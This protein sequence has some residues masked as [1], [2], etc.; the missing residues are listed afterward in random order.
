MLK[1]RSG[2]LLALL[3]LF[4]SVISAVAPAASARAAGT[5][6]TVDGTK[7]GRT[8]DG[9]GAISGG[10]GNSRLLTDY[11]E[12]QRS[13]ILD[14]LFKPGYGAS[15]QIL[16]VEIGGDMNSTDGAEPS[17]MHSPD[18]LNCDRGY[19]WWLM[20][21][22]KKRNPDIKLAALSWGA[23]GWIGKGS[24]WTQDMVDYLMKWLGCAKTHRLPIDYLGG[25][26]ENGFDKAWY[27]NLHTALRANGYATK[28]VAA[29]SGWDVADAITADP[30]FAAAVDIVGAHYP[31]EGGDGGSANT[32]DTPDAAKNVGKPIWASENGSQ[33]YDN[34]APAMARAINLGYV[35]GRM[36]SFINW[37][38]VAALP[39]G[40]PF[41][42]TALTVDDQPWSGRFAIGKQAWVTAHTTQ[43]TRPGWTYVD[44]ASGLLGGDR[45][46]GSYVTLKSPK[47]R[48]YSTV[49]ETTRATADQTVSFS[50]TGGLSTGAVHVWSTD[51]ASK[52]P[53]DDL[54]HVADVTPAGGTYTVTLKPGRVYTLT[55]TTGAGKGTAT[56]GPS[57][58]FGLPYSDTFDHSRTGAIPGYLAPQ[59]GSFEIVP[60]G[61]GRSGKCARQMSAVKPIVWHDNAATPYSLIGDGTWTNYTV[62]ADVMLEQTGSVELL[63]R[64]GGRD[65]W[66]V[67]HIDAYYLRVTDAGDWSIVRGDTG[68]GLTTL[69]SGKVAALGPVSWHRLALTFQ[70]DA[71]TAAIDGRQV[72]TAH[73]STYAAGPAG[74]AVGVGDG[75]N[76]G[77]N[78]ITDPTGDLDWNGPYSLDGDVSGT[79][80]KATTPDGKSAV[81]WK[82]DD[83]KQNTWIQYTP[84]GLA[85]GTSYKASLTLRGK[86]N[87]YLNFYNG[88][89]DVGGQAVQLSDT[90]QTVEVKTT[91]PGGDIRPLQFQV[92]TAGDGPVDLLAS[93]AAIYKQIPGAGWLNAQFDDLKVTPGQNATAGTAYKLVNA[94][95][96]KALS[97]AADGTK[98]VQAADTGAAAQQ[99]RLEGHGTGY[100]EIVGAGGKVLAAPSGAAGAQLEQRADTRAGS[101][102]WR[103]VPTG[104]GHYTITNRDSGKTADV[105]SKD[106]GAAVVQNPGSGAASQR[107]ELVPVPTAGATYR[108]QNVG[109]GLV[110]D[111][112]GQSRDDGGKVVQWTDNGGSNQQWRLKQA[113]SRYVLVN[114][115]SGKVLDVPGAST[116]PATDLDQWTDNGASNQQW[117]LTP[118]PG[119]AYT[120]TNGHSGLAVDIWQ[121]RR[122]PGAGVQQNTPSGAPS[123][124]WRLIPV[125]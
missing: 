82:M 84:S 116:E 28:V 39:P 46:N 16:K 110:M 86:G 118:A 8:F 83:A 80:E 108:L 93:D 111:V 71:I 123:Q 42:T 19:E 1:H 17:H 29:D 89:S 124:E 47:G 66:E 91:V 100:L 4:V 33:D 20:E 87:V 92:R 43:F 27:E 51:L 79:V 18:D 26:N 44:S 104:D 95:S 50:V 52:N 37:P 78:L 35:D 15:L 10:G 74:L 21:Q 63:G 11:P 59:H 13:R 67:G 58:A 55:T 53:A 114:V 23:P 22:A 31:C 112:A 117:Q 5:T 68:G 49:I 72:G 38:L 3:A 12:P 115:N 105:R 120:L 14:Y 125:S 102:Q 56:S 96:G 40:L 2:V 122:D 41:Q 70:G 98:I 25:W 6:V 90:P 48:D 109:S 81:H 106:D 101:E 24:F 97:V 103:F 88:Q 94:G 65:Y 73:D 113:G 61:A 119:G 45:A 64:Y 99:W 75:G 76:V 57:A 30:K 36:T 54:A 107:W 85:Q 60:C 69:A 121:Q 7:G 9:I 34:G 77:G 62:S 32:C